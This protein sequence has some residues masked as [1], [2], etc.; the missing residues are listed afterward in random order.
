MPQTEFGYQRRNTLRHA[1]HDYTSPGAYFVTICEH[2]GRS[3]F[4]QIIDQ[5]MVLNPLGKIAANCITAFANRHPEITLEVSVVMPN[6]VHVLLWLKDDPEQSNAIATGKQR[7]FGDAVAGSL[8]T[9]IGGYKS[10]V[11]QTAKRQGLIPGPPL[12]QDNFYD[13]IIRSDQ[14]LE[15]IRSYIRTNPVRWLAD[16]L[17]P[18]APSNHFN[19]T[20]PRQPQSDGEA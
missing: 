13:H 5:T 6:H 14:E 20:W 19:R 12:W 18:A 16:Q 11:T 10:S 2:Q 17:H 8:S 7:K 15:R 9:L 1:G 4:G 3:V